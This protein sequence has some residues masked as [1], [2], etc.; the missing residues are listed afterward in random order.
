MIQAALETLGLLRGALELSK[1]LD[2]Y[3]CATNCCLFTKS[4]SAS[5]REQGK[6]NWVLGVG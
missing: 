4:R 3:R 1:P 6:N 5:P 2:I